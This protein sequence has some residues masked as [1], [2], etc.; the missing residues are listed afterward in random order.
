VE[1][2]EAKPWT[3]KMKINGHNSRIIL[4]IASLIIILLAAGPLVTR[5]AV[6]DY[7]NPSGPF[8]EGSFGDKAVNFDG[9]LRVVTWNTHYAVNLEQTIQTLEDVEELRDADILL[10]QEIDAEGV[11]TIAQRLRYHYIFYP[12]AFNRQRRIEIGNAILAKWPLRNPDKIVLPNALP[13]WLESR[14]SASATI[15][16]NGREIHV[17]CVHLEISWMLFM[18]GESQVEFLGR[19]AGGKDNIII[20]GGDFNT[21]NPVSIAIL[22]DQMGKI[23][24]KRLTKGTGYTFE[25]AGLKFTLD[26]IF[27]NATLH[28]RAGVYRQTNASDHYPVWAEISIDIDE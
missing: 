20:M 18:R 7:S 6:G 21:W 1:R 27:S 24:L 22:D 2:F 23:G 11:E 16:I 10:L 12:A 4:S 8:F 19:K 17:Y 9:G 26:H 14:N 13:G 5:R 15:L 28:H 25:R 3:V